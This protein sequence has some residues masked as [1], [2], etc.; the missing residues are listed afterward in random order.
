MSG[1]ARRSTTRRPRRPTR[2]CSRPRPETARRGSAA[3]ERVQQQGAWIYGDG[4]HA[5]R[6]VAMEA[7]RALGL[8]A[9]LLEG[10]TAGL[11]GGR[12]RDGVLRPRPARAR[13]ARGARGKEVVG[14]GNG[15]TRR[16]ARRTSPTR[17]LASSRRCRRLRLRERAVHGLAPTAWST[18]AGAA[19]ARWLD[20]DTRDAPASRRSCSPAPRERAA[21]G[22]GRR[23]LLVVRRARR[24]LRAL[25]VRPHGVAA[26][27]AAVRAE[28]VN[29]AVLNSTK[30]ACS[31]SGV[32]LRL[33]ARPWR[34]RRSRTLRRRR[35]GAAARRS[36]RRGVDAFG[37]RRPRRGPRP[38]VPDDLALL[39]LQCSISEFLRRRTPLWAPRLLAEAFGGTNLASVSGRP[40][41][42]TSRHAWSAACAYMPFSSG[43]IP[44]RRRPRPRPGPPADQQVAT[45]AP[46]RARVARRRGRAPPRRGRSAAE[47][48]RAPHQSSPWPTSARRPVDGENWRPGTA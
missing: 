26:A 33:G 18:E 25:D 12:L 27:R 43:P 29:R 39:A 15:W 24:A 47:S 42:P 37:P 45:R 10:A 41:P 46:R 3:I 40:S 11:V 32:A 48:R 19:A 4:G 20:G 44:G 21:A 35:R 7:L 14:R 30:P 36:S 34:R 31:S 16:G 38:Q 22:A 23:G 6:G 13:R 2:T 1:S 9:T 17:G 5:L 28:G 8:G